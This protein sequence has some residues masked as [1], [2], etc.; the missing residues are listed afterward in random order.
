MVPLFA[1]FYQPQPIDDHELLIWLLAL[2]P[3]F[4][5][6]Y[7]RGWRGV[8]LAMT[9]GMV[10]LVA[11]QIVI[12]LTGRTIQNWPLFLMVLAVYIGVALALGWV[13]ELLHRERVE[14]ERLAHEDDL[15]SLPNRRSARTHLDMEFAAARRNRP[16]CVVLLDLDGFKA[17]ND[18]YGHAAGDERLREVGR[19]LAEHT[20][21]MNLTARYGGEEFLSV[22]SGAGV[23][24]AR[25]F[26][27][28]VVAAIRVEAESG[29]EPAQTISA[30]V[31]EYREGM[32]DPGELLAAADAALYQAKAAGGDR[33]VVHG[34][35]S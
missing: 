8:A 34:E 35:A 27:E 11:T 5:L 18:R 7:Y 26:A 3:A 30:G 13:T 19:L 25:A 29:G 9:V 2:V 28:R 1:S 31:A 23:A 21:E 10:V 32:E 20:R 4:F 22:L 12:L 16:L 14:A 33:V 17:Y 15:T 6:S 24:G